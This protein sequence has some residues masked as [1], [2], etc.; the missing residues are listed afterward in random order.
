MSVFT[1]KGTKPTESVS[2][3][4]GDKPSVNSVF[5]RVDSKG[6]ISIPSFLR[7]NFGLKEGDSLQFIFDLRKEFIIFGL[8][9]EVI[10]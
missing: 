2:S 10:I 3:R 7:K 5:V 4:S 6:R 8:Q 9:K 1:K